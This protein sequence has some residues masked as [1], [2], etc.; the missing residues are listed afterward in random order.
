MNSRKNS[1]WTVKETYKEADEEEKRN[2]CTQEDPSENSSEREKEGRRNPFCIHG[3]VT[4]WKTLGGE[5][6]TCH[7]QGDALSVNLFN[8]H[9]SLHF[10]RRQHRVTSPIFTLHLRSDIVQTVF[11]GQDQTVFARLV[12]PSSSTQPSIFVFTRRGNKAKKKKTPFLDI[13][14]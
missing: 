9:P 8:L 1:G 2:K 14:S 4:I 10:T 12:C 11:H 3:P 5:P 6:L 13:F 7:S